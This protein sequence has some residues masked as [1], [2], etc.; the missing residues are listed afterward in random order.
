[1]VLK[2]SHH[3]CSVLKVL[4]NVPQS[5]KYAKAAQKT[6]RSCV[7]Q[8]QQSESESALSEFDML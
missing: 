3:W 8:L 7:D 5:D 4:H 2:S 6:Q 1:M